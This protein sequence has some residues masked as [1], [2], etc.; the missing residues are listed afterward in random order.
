[1]RLPGFNAE[2]SVETA[3]NV[4][5]AAMRGQPN[6]RGRVVSAGTETVNC[7]CGGGGTGSGTGGGGVPGVCACSSILG[8]GCSTTGNQCNPG[9]VPQCSC[10]FLGNSCQCVPSAQ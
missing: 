1:M 10:G 2:A 4:I 3:I 9:F 8:A 5:V 6:L 7:N